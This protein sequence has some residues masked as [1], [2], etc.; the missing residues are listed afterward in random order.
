MTSGIFFSLRKVLSIL[1]R[2]L[3]EITSMDI[4]ALPPL[5]ICQARSLFLLCAHKYV[6]KA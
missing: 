6:T 1:F 3:H 4:L 2:V 5:V